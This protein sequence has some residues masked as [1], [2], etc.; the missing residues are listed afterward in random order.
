MDRIDFS[1]YSINED[2]GTATLHIDGVL[3][4]GVTIEDLRGIPVELEGQTYAIKTAVG[5]KDAF[6]S[7]ETKSYILHAELIAEEEDDDPV[8]DEVLEVL[9]T[10]S[11]TLQAILETLRG[12]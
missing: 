8:Q 2:E 7:N 12:R 9:Y 1:D 4:E 5:A 11:N 3:P 6:F 10:I